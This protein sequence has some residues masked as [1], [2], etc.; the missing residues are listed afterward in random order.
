MLHQQ[1]EFHVLLKHSCIPKL[2]EQGAAHEVDQCI[3]RRQR[4]DMQATR[5]ITK[6]H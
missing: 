4:Q 3:L 1:R 5:G 2:V 6:V